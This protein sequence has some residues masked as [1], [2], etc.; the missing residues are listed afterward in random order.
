MFT[1]MPGVNLYPAGDAQITTLSAAVGLTAPSADANVA[2]V[3]AES[4]NVRYRADNT[5]PTASV[6]EL[7]YAG[8]QGTWIFGDLKKYKFIEASAS[9]KL[10]V[11]FFTA[12]I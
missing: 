3:Q 12:K 10:N 6:G 7:L 2:R 9:A 11:Q 5:D 4:Q 1:F 8:D